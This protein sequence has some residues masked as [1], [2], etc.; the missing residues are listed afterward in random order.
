MPDRG[1]RGATP[2]VR[3]YL[4]FDKQRE[5]SVSISHGEKWADSMTVFAHG[6]KTKLSRV[7]LQR[8]TV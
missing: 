8:V 7:L 2:E 4:A 6:E 1:I 3:M 5:L